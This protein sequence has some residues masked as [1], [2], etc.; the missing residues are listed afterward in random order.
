MARVNGWYFACNA[1]YPNRCYRFFSGCW[2]S[3]C[4][5]C[6]LTWC[7]VVVFGV[8][9]WLIRVFPFHFFFLSSFGSCCR[10]R[11]CGGS[12]GGQQREKKYVKKNTCK[13]T[14]NE[15]HCHVN[16]PTVIHRPCAR[17]THVLICASDD[18]TSVKNEMKT[19]SIEFEWKESHAGEIVENTREERE[20][21]RKDK[22][23]IERVAKNRKKKLKNWENLEN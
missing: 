11:L 2:L 14:V 1:Y 19:Q 20:R 22:E 8:Q 12:T 7:L 5:V 9:L 16:N 4:V 3:V 21:E 13:I 10:R 15:K 18:L 23:K 17:H 6:R